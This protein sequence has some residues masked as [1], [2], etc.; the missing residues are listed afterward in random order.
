MRV[1][2][3]RHVCEYCNP[4]PLT[5]A[6]RLA[7]PRVDTA[8]LPNGLHACWKHVLTKRETPREVAIRL[9][10]ETPPAYPKRAA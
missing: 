1:I 8:K 2:P 4:R 10:R 6:E 3:R 9:N 7:L 5:R